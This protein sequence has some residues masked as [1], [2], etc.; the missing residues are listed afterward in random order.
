MSD[1]IEIRTLTD[2]AA[3]SPDEFMRF[4][5]DLVIWHSLAHEALDLGAYEATMIW[6][7]DGKN[8]LL[9]SV[10]EVTNGKA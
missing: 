3:L 10:I 1:R 2:I 5:P 8:E 7:D 9:P 4:L 6:V